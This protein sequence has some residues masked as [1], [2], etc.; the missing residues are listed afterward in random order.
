ML[1]RIAIGIASFVVLDGLWLG[2]VMKQFYRSELGPIALTAPDGSLAPI[3]LAAAPVYV[4]MAIGIAVFVMPK[5]E[6]GTA[7]T[8]LGYGALFGWI[9]FGVYDLTNYSTLRGYSP[10]LTIVDIAW[11]G[12]SC[13]LTSA[14]MKA[15]GSPKS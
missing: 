1:K 3:W 4:L 6:K 10:V 14:V 11:G 2:V 15:L 13:A 5:V 12:V 9:L 7:L 8:A